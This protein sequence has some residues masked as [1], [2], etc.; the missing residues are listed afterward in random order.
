MN[1]RLFIW[2]YFLSFFFLHIV[3]KSCCLTVTG[4]QPGEGGE[5]PRSRRSFHHGESLQWFD[6]GDTRPA[7]SASLTAVVRSRGWNIYQFLWRRGLTL[8]LRWT[9]SSL[10][11]SP[12]G[13]QSMILSRG[14][15]EGTTRGQGPACVCVCKVCHS[16]SSWHVLL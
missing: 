9:L 6:E 8:L 11:I 2:I 13:W 16:F 7:C 3:V 1:Q 15:R 14:E 4:A 12:K 5:D 10:L